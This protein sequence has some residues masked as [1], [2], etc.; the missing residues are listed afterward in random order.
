MDT[1]EIIGYLASAAVLISFLMKDV[2]KLRLIN[3]VGCILFVIYGY[4]LESWPV[5]ITNAAI[6]MVNAYYVI[7]SKRA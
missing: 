7:Q 5:I 4:M 2:N 6:I 3:S 1:V